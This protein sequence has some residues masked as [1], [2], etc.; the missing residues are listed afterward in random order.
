MAGIL[1]ENNHQITDAV[2]G[3]PGI[4]KKLQA[5]M[6][7]PNGISK[8]LE[9]ATASVTNGDCLTTKV[10]LKLHISLMSVIECNVFCIQWFLHVLLTHALVCHTIYALSMH[11]RFPKF[12]IQLI[13]TYVYCCFYNVVAKI[14]QSKRRRV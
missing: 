2:S 12:G 7:E 9:V 13:C 6:T 14:C 10:Q 1:T 11:C 3:S 8:P 5:K 4:V